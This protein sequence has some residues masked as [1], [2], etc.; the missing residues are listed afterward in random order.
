MSNI[1]MNIIQNFKNYRYKNSHSL[2][3]MRKSK[4]RESATLSQLY[5]G[6][7]PNPLLKTKINK[8]GKKKK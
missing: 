2:S 7:D 8:Y 4:L 1:C 5:F 3:L 6:E